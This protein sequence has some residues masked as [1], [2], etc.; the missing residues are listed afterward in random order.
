MRRSFAA[1]LGTAAMIFIAACSTDQVSDRPLTPTDPLFAPGGGGGNPLCSGNLASDIAKEQKLLYLDAAVLDVMEDQFTLIKNACPIIE[2]DPADLSVLLEYFRLMV[3]NRTA[4]TGGIAAHL[5]SV[6][7]YA[8]GTGLVRAGSVF[9]DLGAADVLTVTESSGDAIVS[10]DKGAQ[11]AFKPN[12]VAI[13]QAGTV[14]FGQRFFTFQPLSAEECGDVTGLRLGSRGNGASCYDIQDYPDAIEYID[15]ATLTLCMHKPTGENVGI[16]HQKTGYGDEVLPVENVSYPCGDFHTSSSSS[17]L[18]QKG[19]LGRVLARAYDFFA[20]KTLIA[21]DVGESGSI[22]SFSKVGAVLTDI[23]ED[24]FDDATSFNPNPAADYPDLG[25]DGATWVY[26]AQSPGYIRIEDSFGG[27]TGGV[28]VLSQGQGA[29]NNCPV[30]KLLGEI[31]TVDEPN[32]VGETDFETN[33]SFEVIWTSVQTKP[34]VK[35]APFVLLNGTN[36]TDAAREIVRL[37]YVSQSNQN[38]LLL[39][40]PG[41]GNSVTTINAGTWVQNV[42]QTFKITINLDVLNN[43]QDKTVSLSIRNPATNEFE[44]VAG[45]QNISAVRATSFKHIGYVLTGIDAGIIGSDDWRVT[46][47]PDIPPQ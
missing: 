20:P 15:P 46:R 29:C 25:D 17:W 9:T 23:F 35:E 11:L 42:S 26:S 34:S 1:S 32:T 16:V 2:S 44:P 33:G 5:F 45:A 21:D 24:N 38:R 39:K 7:R 31:R 43:A 13:T 3:E 41:T 22:G 30:F 8:T 27:L 19:P 18:E 36:G 6:S 28:L 47:L 12:T 37:S 14:P 10:F 40:I 4:D